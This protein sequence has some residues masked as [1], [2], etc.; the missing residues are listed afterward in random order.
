MALEIKIKNRIKY[1]A[2]V[3]GFFALGCA[4]KYIDGF[5]QYTIIKG[6]EIHEQ[7]KNGIIYRSIDYL[8]KDH[9][10]H[11]ATKVCSEKYENAD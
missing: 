4:P 9:S 10:E 5:T 2:L 7:H 1:L 3:S 6:K 11:Y 8:D